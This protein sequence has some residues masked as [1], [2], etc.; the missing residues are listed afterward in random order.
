MLEYK[1]V[2]RWED[3]DLVEHIDNPEVG[4]W[5]TIKVDSDVADGVAMGLAIRRF[6]HDYCGTGRAGKYAETTVDILSGDATTVI[7]K[8]PAN[9]YHQIEISLKVVI[10]DAGFKLRTEK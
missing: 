7:V 4:E 8:D 3:L 9:Y 10:A 6:L 1:I 2:K 5:A